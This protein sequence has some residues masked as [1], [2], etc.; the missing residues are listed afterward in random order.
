MST[1]LNIGLEELWM[2]AG[3]GDTTRFIGLHA[4]YQ[5]IPEIAKAL[6]GCDLT[7]KVGTK[8]SAL[9]GPV[10]LLADFTHNCT[11]ANS[12]TFNKLRMEYFHHSGNKAGI[13]DLPPT[14]NTIKMDIKRSFYGAHLI[15]Q[16]V[17]NYTDPEAKVVLD[18]YDYG[19]E[20]IYNNVMPSGEWLSIPECYTKVCTCG[21]CARQS[22]PCKHATEMMCL[23]QAPKS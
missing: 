8:K 23:L 9:K 4:L 5:K 20:M 1:Y 3:R 19:Y 10:E 14:S 7:S 16:A 6:P 17:H 2:R 12:T 21:L 13:Q 22:C 15:V 11:P 18:F